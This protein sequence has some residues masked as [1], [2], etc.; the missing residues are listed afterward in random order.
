MNRRLGA[1][2]QVAAWV[3]L[4]RDA[5]IAI[6]VPF[7]HGKDCIDCGGEG[8]YA[9][10]FPEQARR[11]ALDIWERDRHRAQGLL[12]FGERCARHLRAALG[13][14]VEVVSLSEIAPEGRS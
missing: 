6:E 12:C 1:W 8:A 10:M 7:Q 13:P 9:R 5:G 3:K 14:E 4:A 11:M 2:E